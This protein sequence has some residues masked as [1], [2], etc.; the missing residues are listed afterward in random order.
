MR[1]FGGLAAACVVA[2]LCACTVFESKEAAWFRQAEGQA[3]QE[4][5]RRQWGEP[6]TSRSLETGESLWT[7]EKREQQSGNR[8]AA[9]GMWCNE[10]ALIF[11]RQGILRRWTHRSYFH[12]G[13]LMPR[14]CIP[15]A[16]SM[17][18][19]SKRV[20]GSVG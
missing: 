6:I 4:E 3:T 16:Q 20:S 7:Y 9:P 8:Y 2:L 1:P 10:Y 15:D 19:L 5:V 12:G 17:G 18:S 14:E 11:D 13:E